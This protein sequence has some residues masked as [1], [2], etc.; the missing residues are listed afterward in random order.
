[1]KKVEPLAISSRKI[2]LPVASPAK[3]VESPVAV[4]EEEEEDDDD[5]DLFG[6]DDEEE[7]QEAARLREERLQ[8]YA[9]KKSKKPGLIAKSSILLDVKPVSPLAHPS[10]AGAGAGGA[11]QWVEQPPLH[12]RVLSDLFHLPQLKRVLRSKILH[13]K[14]LLGSISSIYHVKGLGCNVLEMP[15]TLETATPCWRKGK[16]PS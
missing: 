5:I 1:M 7:D 15:V 2:D 10:R 13:V 8:Q 3:K 14:N 6:S 9:A 16:G 11:S 12:R 4:E